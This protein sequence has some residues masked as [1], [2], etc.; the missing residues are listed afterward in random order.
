M[1]NIKDYIGKKFAVKCDNSKQWEKLKE[2]CGDS[3]K[4]L[5]N[6]DEILPY[7]SL[8]TMGGQVGENSLVN[9]DYQELQ[10]SDFVF[11][12][13]ELKGV[14]MEVSMFGDSF[15]NKDIIYGKNENHYIGKRGHW[16]YAR[17]IKQNTLELT[18][19]EIAEKFGVDKV[20]VKG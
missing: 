2:L 20:I 11:E 5:N 14:E 8:C 3:L 13:P 7:F 4:E 16:L 12:V 1:K 10:F 9:L 6:Y 17:P 19:E 18:I 15:I